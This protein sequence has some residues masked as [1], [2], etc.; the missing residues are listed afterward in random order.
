MF[1]CFK[2]KTTPEVKPAPIPSP[3]YGSTVPVAIIVGHNK[4]A[5][6]ATNYLGESEYAFNSRIA[7]K[8][9]ER[10]AGLGVNAAVIFRPTGGYSYQCSE[11]AK[12]VKMLKSTFAIELHFNDASASA[13]GCEVLIRETASPSDN[14]FADHLT[15]LLDSRLGINQRGDD[16][17]KTI[18]SGH[19][20]Y[21][22]LE[23]LGKVGAISCIVEPCFAKN[24][25]QSK[26]VFENEDAYVSTL[27]TALEDLT[28][29]YYRK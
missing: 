3:T 9:C 27:V 17:V 25:A 20:G 16:G 19:N 13:K 23:A 10:L 6:G 15:D 14:H 5:Q 12:Q 11:V 21:G 7:R 4:S 26:A 22:M 29:V 18:Y 8:V 1:D 24:R 28:K 2:D